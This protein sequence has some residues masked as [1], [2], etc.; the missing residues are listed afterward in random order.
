[1]AFYCA[2]A[3]ALSSGPPKTEF[4]AHELLTG[5]DGQGCLAFCPEGGLCFS[6]SHLQ[7]LS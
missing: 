5:S 3:Y 1:M 2:L 4:R 6:A 7:V